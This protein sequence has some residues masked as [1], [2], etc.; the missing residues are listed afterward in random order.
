MLSP[1]ILL[2]PRLAGASIQGDR[3]MS[4]SWISL[5][6]GSS[7][8]SL[9][10]YEYDPRGFRTDS[11]SWV[12]DTT[13]SMVSSTRY[14]YDDA[15]R[16]LSGATLVSGDTSSSFRNSW[17]DQELVCT[18][19]RSAHGVLKYVDSFS[20]GPAG[21]KRS[22]RTLADGSIS[23]I[24]VR[25]STASSVLDTLFEPD[26]GGTA[27]PSR[28]TTAFLDGRG[29]VVRE[30]ER[31]NQAGT[32]YVS[33]TT[34]MGY[35]SGRLASVSDLEGDGVAG[36]LADSSAYEYDASGNRTARTLFDSDRRPTDRWTWTWSP[37]LSTRLSD[38]TE[39]STA[40]LVGRSL[41]VPEGT[42]S[43]RLFGLLGGSFGSA[44]MEGNTRAVLPAGL[45]AGRYVASLGSASGTR[46][47]SFTFLDRSETSRLP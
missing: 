42:R 47:V 22:W 6:S 30:Q 16:L 18:V 44:T 32:W 2:L 26:A 5:S 19:L 20:N 41:E 39:P 23:W 12:P 13:G 27:S 9:T 36:V 3:L 11:K 28:I 46:L 25:D 34:V 24:E 7:G 15:G 8:R 43:V 31:I 29:F 37:G 35:A 40:R 4:E 33:R 1:L 17:N 21:R 38:R 45:R 10:L 14:E